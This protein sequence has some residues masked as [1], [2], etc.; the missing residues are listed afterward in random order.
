MTANEDKRHTVL[1]HE[2]GVGKTNVLERTHIFITQSDLNCGVASHLKTVLNERVG[3]PLAQLTLFH[4]RQTEQETGEGRA[5]PVVG[6]GLRSEAIS[7]LIVATILKEAPHRPDEISIAATQLQ[8]VASNLPTQSVARLEY[9]V[10]GVHWCRD[11]G[12]AHSRV[13]LHSEPRGANRTLAAKT[14]SRDSKLRDDVVGK[15]IRRSAMHSQ[16]GSRN[17]SHV[18]EAGTKDAIPTHSSVLRQIVM[19]RAK[20]WK[21][22]RHE[23]AFAAKRI[24]R[25]QTVSAFESLIKTNRGLIGNVVFVPHVEIIVAVG[26][27][28]DYLGNSHHRHAAA[29]HSYVHVWA[30][31]VLP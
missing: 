25:K 13:A 24:T 6:R 7:E 16:T 3:V 27:A 8:T 1:E 18:D 20:A 9:R 23:T 19:N 30:R 5:R 4:S 12:V 31:Y 15:T 17:R 21:V 28:A 22:L 10:P 29:V 14:N 26:A 2:I 11:V